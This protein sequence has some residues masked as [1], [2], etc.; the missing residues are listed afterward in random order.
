MTIRKKAAIFLCLLLACLVIVLYVVS[1]V[2]VERSIKRLEINDVQLNVKRAVHMLE[3]D[4]ESLQSTVKDWAFWDD[5]YAFVEDLNQ[6]YIENNLADPTLMNLNLNLVLFANTAGE[7]VF[8]KSFDLQSQEE[9]PVPHSVKEY[10]AD[11]S[12]LLTYSDIFKGESGIIL[13]PEA[14]MLVASFPILTS[15]LEGPSRGTLIMGRYLD[16]REVELLGERTQ[17]NL[18]AIPFSE[19][20]LS[21]FSSISEKETVAVQALSADKIAGYTVLEDIYGRPALILQAVMARHIY[22]AGRVTVRYFVI[23]VVAIAVLFSGTVFFAQKE[24]MKR[25]TRLYMAV[26]EI[27]ATADA[28]KQIDLGGEEDELAIIARAINDTLKKLEQSQL[29][30]QE[31]E[32]KYRNLV[33]LSSEGIAIIQDGLLKY[34]NPRFVELTG[35]TIGAMIEAPLRHFFQSREFTR[36]SKEKRRRKGQASPFYETILVNRRG[37]DIYLALNKGTITYQ[38]KRAELLI[39]HDVTYR[40]KYEEKLR[41]LSLHDT[42]TGVYNRT[43]FEE[44]LQRLAGDREYPVTIIVSDLDGL[45]LINDFFG[46]AK[47]D[48]LLKRC[49]G[50]LQKHLRKSDVLARVGGD[51]F[52]VILPCTDE[53]DSENIVN[54]IRASLELYN[55]KNP[56]LHLSISLGAATASSPDQS[57]EDIFK[58]ADDLMYRDKINHSTSARNQIVNALLAALAERDYRA[59]GHAKRLQ[60]MCHKLGEKLGLSS[61]QLADLSL[62]ARLHDLGKVGIPD[63]ILNKEGSFSDDEWKTMHRHPEVG[64]RIADSSPN[65]APISKLILYHHERWDGKGYPHG[66]KGEAIPIEC[67]ILALADSFDAMTN[68]RPY[69]KAMSKKDALSEIHKCSGTQF[70]PSLAEKFIQI[71]LEE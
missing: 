27:G 54:R 21:S 71:I 52:A 65:L 8:G 3:R 6:S 35:F 18:S 39:V 48:E 50:L 38:G 9:V 49:A 19:D 68:D 70:D 7:I 2:I 47:G 16:P 24:I 66:L 23:S 13:L 37:D 17:L 15:R 56:E 45:K 64:Y 46:H 43:Y 40:E 14:P 36:E 28:F 10:L 58:R 22:K 4:L 31:S 42:L 11:D 53:R 41:Y 34:V 57:L 51:E 20:W 25:F 67:R 12:V 44:E 62:L 60:E 69:R 30:I 1:G 59:Q 29:V 33:E 26:Q 63:S 32:E 55:K 5:T 61:N